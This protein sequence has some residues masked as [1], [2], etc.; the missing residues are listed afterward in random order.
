MSSSSDDLL[1]PLPSEV[2]GT[3]RAFHAYCRDEL[4]RRRSRDAALHPARYAAAVRL[5]LARLGL[6]SEG[7]R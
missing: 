2:R 3:P 1:P 4:E 6:K 7:D 5:V